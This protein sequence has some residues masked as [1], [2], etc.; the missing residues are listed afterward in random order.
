MLYF[1]EMPIKT[2]LEYDKIASKNPI[3]KKFT[4]IYKKSTT[5]IEHFNCSCL[6][7]HN[8]CT[9]YTNRPN[10]C[11][12]YPLSSFLKSSTIPKHC[13]FNLARTDLILRPKNQTLQ[14]LIN[15][16]MLDF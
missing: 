15:Q 9:D 7:T 14:K 4:P 2:K 6:N 5:N 3:Y 10:F 1:Q 16:V 12:N 13:G 8:K 11:R